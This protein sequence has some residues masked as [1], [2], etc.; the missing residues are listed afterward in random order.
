MDFLKN[1]VYFD[2][3]SQ[4]FLCVT[5][6]YKLMYVFTNKKQHRACITGFN[7]ESDMLPEWKRFK[8]G[9]DVGHG[10]EGGT[11]D[12]LTKLTAIICCYTCISCSF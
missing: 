12:K 4:P 10:G 6:D 5:I 2:G 1:W 8:R 9:R 11:E 3:L 7:Y